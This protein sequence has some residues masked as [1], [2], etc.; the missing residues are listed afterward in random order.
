MT[1]SK[2]YRLEFFKWTFLPAE[3]ERETKTLQ[4]DVCCEAIDQNFHC[5]CELKGLRKFAFIS[6]SKQK[7]AIEP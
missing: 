5:G 7:I 1:K 4:F 2:K 6:G 3:L